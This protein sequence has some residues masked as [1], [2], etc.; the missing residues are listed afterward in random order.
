MPVQSNKISLLRHFSQNESKIAELYLAYSDKFPERVKLW[1]G[2]AKD[3]LRHSA[4]LLDLDER[5]GE[6]EG[7]WQVSSNAPAILEYISE[8]IETCL[9]KVKSESLD[10]KEALNNALSLEQSMIEKKSFEIFASANSEIISVLE[11][12][13][14]ETE[15]HKQWL[16]KYLKD[17]I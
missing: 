17:E 1:Q 4:L 8:F 5:F 10:L 16:L 12:L 13:N 6:V 11:K 15:G 2:L 3:E 7:N 9:A 14:R